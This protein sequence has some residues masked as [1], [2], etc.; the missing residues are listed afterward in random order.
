[1]AASPTS[2]PVFCPW[3]PCDLCPD[4]WA[5]AP[6]PS[7]APSSASALQPLGSFISQV[8]AVLAVGMHLPSASLRGHSGELAEIWACP[9]PRL[10]CRPLWGPLARPDP[11]LSEPTPSEWGL[12]V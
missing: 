12:E 11:L 5:W 1:M 2:L 4:R 10:G 8:Q 9:L 3:D 6:L 7:P